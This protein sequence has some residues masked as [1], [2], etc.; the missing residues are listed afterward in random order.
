[1]CDK[2]TVQDRTQNDK[3]IHTFSHQTRHCV[4]LSLNDDEEIYSVEEKKRSSSELSVYVHVKTCIC[5][6]WVSL[7]TDGEQ[8]LGFF[9][10]YE[11]H[12]AN[13]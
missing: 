4:K 3:S 6:L 10:Q 9:L 1:M 11:K 2:Y 8:F 5:T 13:T 7:S 12:C